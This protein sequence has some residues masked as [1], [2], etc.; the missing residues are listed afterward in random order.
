MRVLDTLLTFLL[1]LIALLVLALVIANWGS[2][3]AASATVGAWATQLVDLGFICLRGLGIFAVL[4]GIY[5]AGMRAWKRAQDERRQRDGSFPL[6]RMRVHGGLVLVDPNKMI[7]PAIAVG[8]GGVAEVFTAPIEA[9]LAHAEARARV[10]VAQALAPG[11]DAISSKFGSMFSPGRFGR[12]ERALVEGQDKRTPRIIGVDPDR[13]LP[14]PPAEPVRLLTVDEAVATAAPD[15]LLIGQNE[16]GQPAVFNPMLHGHAGIVGGTGTGKTTSAAFTAAVAAL[17]AGYGLV[18]LDPEGGTDWGTFQQ[19]AELLETDRETFPGQVT[20]LVREY[21]RR[22][23]NP[24]A[25]RLL[26]VIEEYGDLIRQLRAA[27]RSDAEHVDNALDLLLRRGRKRGIHLLLVDQYPEHWSQQVIAGV[28]FRAVFRLGPNQGAKMEEY[29][30][31]KLPNRGVFLH[32]SVPYEAWHAEPAMRRL[33]ATVPALPPRVIDGQFTA[34]SQ[35]VHGSS[36]PVHGSSQ[37]VHGSSW[38]VHGA[39]HGSS[40]EVAPPPPSMNASVNAVPETVDGWYEWTLAEYL[41]QHPELLQVDRQGRGVGVKTL[42]EAMAAWS[43]GTPAEYEAMKGTASEVAK[44]LRSEVSDWW[45]NK[46]K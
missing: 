20:A 30:A 10:S 6:Q 26:V 40:P 31:A 12:Q 33:L 11:D 37:P 14:A 39:V 8:S 18:I 17:R 3:P 25:S 1:I 36:Q 29:Q 41:P 22:A 28:K 27:N 2:M 16:A 13:Q 42:A 21:E 4:G 46:G 7:G 23:T 24:A 9:H 38:P 5:I 44:R 34:S 19:H 45:E 15:R 32:D 35:A 43:R